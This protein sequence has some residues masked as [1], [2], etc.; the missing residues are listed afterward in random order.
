MKKEKS[1]AQRQRGRD[2]RDKGGEYMGNDGREEDKKA[3]R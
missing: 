1:N 2:G 3:M